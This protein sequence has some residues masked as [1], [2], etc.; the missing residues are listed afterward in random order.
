MQRHDCCTSGD[1]LNFNYIL[2]I[3]NRI[4]NLL[5]T[6]LYVYTYVALCNDELLS[7]LFFNS[8]SVRKQRKFFT[9]INIKSNAGLENHN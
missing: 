8:S 7:I 9:N 3:A 2:T 6:S 4:L 1:C 5:H